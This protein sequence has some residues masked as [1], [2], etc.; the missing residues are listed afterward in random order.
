MF[1][2]PRS[3]IVMNSINPSPEQQQTIINTAVANGIA[4]LKELNSKNIYWD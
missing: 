4:I 2:I 1:K 3:E